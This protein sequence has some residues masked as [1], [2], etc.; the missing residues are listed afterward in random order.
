MLRAKRR[1]TPRQ[2]IARQNWERWS[3]ARA[4]ATPKPDALEK[5]LA[6]TG[7]DAS[8]VEADPLK[9]VNWRTEEQ[10]ARARLSAAIIRDYE[11]AFLDPG[12]VG[13]WTREGQE[14]TLPD[15]ERLLIH[16]LIDNQRRAAYELLKQR[17]D[18][19]AIAAILLRPES[20][21]L[22]IQQEFQIN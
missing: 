10:W 14:V 13:A 16:D 22:A 17:V 11:E 12:D 4:K 19:R 5:A 20:W 18:T 8:A 1:P 21:V 3:A 7:L 6:G 15:G 2:K 9:G